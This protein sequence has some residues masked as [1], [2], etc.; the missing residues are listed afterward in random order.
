MDLSLHYAVV[1]ANNLVIISLPSNK[2]LIYS[3][4]Q[5]SNKRHKPQTSF[6][7]SHPLLSLHPPPP[8]ISSPL[9]TSKKQLA[10]TTALPCWSMVEAPRRT[11]SINRSRILPSTRMPTKRRGRGGGIVTTLLLSLLMSCQCHPPSQ[12][13]SLHLTTKRRGRGG[14]IH[15]TSLLISCQC[16]RVNK[17]SFLIIFYAIFS[18]SP[19]PSPQPFTPNPSLSLSDMWR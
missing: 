5:Q 4:C 15:N 11:F 7:L 18:L 10:P 2:H 13:L 16:S 9:P 6:S 8:H 17:Q 19:S 12:T 3:R 14:T 1:S